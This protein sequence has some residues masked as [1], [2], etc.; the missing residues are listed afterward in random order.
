MAYR[1]GT[2]VAFA[3]DG[4]FD[5]TKSDIKYYN[6]LKGWN[7]MKGKTFKLINPHE[8]GAMLRQFSK[9]ETIKRTLRA[10]LDN[11]TRL[12][13]LVGNTTKLD[14]DF[15][16]YEIEYAID[17]C[18]LFVIVSYVNHRTR[19]SNHCPQNLINLIPKSLKDRID[20]NSVKTLHIPF[21]ERIINEA[22]KEYN[23]DTLTSFSFGGYK[24]FVY[25]R[26][27]QPHEI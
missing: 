17:K 26:I 23:H 20:N 5:I 22:I 12:L 14:M 10:R 9:E 18:K 15:V 7:K 4:N 27:Y 25:D 24:E 13:L 8:K 16:P 2:Y 3:A 11:S 6:L 1:N 19:I 21:R